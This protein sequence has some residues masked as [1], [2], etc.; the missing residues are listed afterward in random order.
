M[1]RKVRCLRRKWTN[2]LIEKTVMIDYILSFFLF[3]SHLSR[4]ANP[5]A[6]K[7]IPNPMKDMK[8]GL[9]VTMNIIPSGRKHIPNIKKA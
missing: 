2:Y 9:T 5:I 4:L 8:A 7:Q 6:M 3:F 1:T